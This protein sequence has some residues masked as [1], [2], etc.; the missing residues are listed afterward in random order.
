MPRRVVFHEFGGIENLCVEPAPELVA[1]PGQVLVRVVYAGLNPS[2]L[3]IMAGTF[4]I[5]PD[6]PSGCGN[7]FSGVVAGVGAGVEGLAVGDLV[8]GGRRLAAA[9]DYSLASPRDL[10]VLPAGLGLDVAG[11]LQIAGTTAVAGVRAIAPSEDE[12]VFVS[13]AAGGVGVLAAQLSRACGARVIGSASPANFDFLRA[14]GV[15][16]VDY[17]G[18]MWDRLRELAPAGISAAFSTRGIDE[19]NGLLNFG[20]PASRINAVAAG[21]TAGELGV[22]TD[23]SA[24]ALPDDL[25]RL[26]R[27]LAVG[28]IM[29]PIDSV[30]SLDSAQAAY[31]RLAAGHLRGKILLSTADVRNAAGLM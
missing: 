20:V 10:H 29:L 2:D 11:G 30:Y 26:A 13:G 25:D 5:V 15:I 1:G 23:G 31:R 24:A 4:F 28:D 17:D 3:R 8:F 22:H 19:V 7:D 9:A 21:S 6:L 18:G 14:L 16:P 12:T 27:A